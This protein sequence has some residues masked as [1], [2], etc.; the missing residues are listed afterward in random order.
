MKCELFV[1]AFLSFDPVSEINDAMLFLNLLHEQLNTVND[2]FAL[3]IFRYLLFLLCFMI[4]LSNLFMLYVNNAEFY[5]FRIDQFL[6]ALI[7]DTAQHYELRR[8]YML[9]LKH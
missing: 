1:D 5:L 9:G 3:V 8:M 7:V 6:S 2:Y 4:N